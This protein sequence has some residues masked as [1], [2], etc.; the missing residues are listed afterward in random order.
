M[1]HIQE[2]LFSLLPCQYKK[3]LSEVLNNDT[4]HTPLNLSSPF[5]PDV[6]AEIRI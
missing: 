4:S 2:Q 1:A 5:I 3:Q 6:G